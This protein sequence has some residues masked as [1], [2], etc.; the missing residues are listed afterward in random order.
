M[1][2]TKLGQIIKEFN[3]ANYSLWSKFQ[4]WAI[5]CTILLCASHQ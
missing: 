3:L 4:G 1:E 5:Y 2:L